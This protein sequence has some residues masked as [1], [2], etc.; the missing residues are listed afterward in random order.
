[1]IGCTPSGYI[2]YIGPF[3]GGKASDKVLFTESG[4]LNKCTSDD[5]LMVDKGFP[6]WN[7]CDAAIT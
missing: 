5:A 3:Y 2:S 1:L 7:E 6:V 4:I